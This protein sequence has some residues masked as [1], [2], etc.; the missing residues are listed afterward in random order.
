MALDDI[1]LLAEWLVGVPLMQRYGLTV[2]SAISSLEA[3]LARGDWMLVA[4]GDRLAIGFAWAMP[5]GAFG[6]S[7]YLRL[8]AVPVDMS[9]TGTGAQLLA[10]IE[11]M[12]A[13]V[14]NDLFLLTSDFNEKAQRFYERHGYAQVGAISDYVV[15]GVTELMF[16]KRLK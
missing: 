16:R 2:A 6:R 12:A 5:S 11:R 8:I 13:D 3:G 9:G 15:P 7:A 10:E 4:D 14:S 1:P